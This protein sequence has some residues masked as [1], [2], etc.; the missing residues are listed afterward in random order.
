[1]PSMKWYDT[2]VPGIR[3][4]QSTT[5]HPPAGTCRVTAGT[6]IYICELKGT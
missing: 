5:T 3:L 4:K 6:Y 1:M 2:K